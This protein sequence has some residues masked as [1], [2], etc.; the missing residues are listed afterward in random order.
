MAPEMTTV[1]KPKSRPAKA[2][3]IVA[4][5]SLELI[6]IVRWHPR[7]PNYATER[8]PRAANGQ[9]TF[10]AECLLA[11]D[12]GETACRMSVYA[13]GFPG[14]FLA[15]HDR[16]YAAAML[17]G[18][19]PCHWHLTFHA[20]AVAGLQSVAHA[21]SVEAKAPFKHVD[22]CSSFAKCIDGN[23]GR[24]RWETRRPAPRDGN[25]RPRR[26]TASL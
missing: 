13:D 24:R 10:Q 12:F 7:V 11:R 23:V 1:S 16:Q 17:V 19:A 2:P 5:S 20:G 6:G 3:E 22:D 25:H 14:T 21:A 8:K 26:S 18:R 15:R 9:R 4:R